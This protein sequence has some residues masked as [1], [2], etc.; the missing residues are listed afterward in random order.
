MSATTVSRVVR[1]A[2]VFT[3]VFALILVG[4]GLTVASLR[5]TG[6]LD[7]AIAALRPG[8][9]GAGL[10]LMLVGLGMTGPR[11]LVLL[12]PGAPGERPSALGASTLFL[13]VTV[14]NLSFPGPAGELAAAVA[15]KRRHGIPATTSIAASLHGRFAGLAG[16]GLCAMVLLPFV[17]V[18]EDHVWPLW[19]VAGGFG[20]AGL[21]LSGLALRP[22]LLARL[23][24][25]GP[26]W[27]AARLP[28][29][30]GRLCLRVQ[31]VVTDLADALVASARVGLSRWA[32]ALAWSLAAHTLYGLAVVCCGYGVAVSVPLLPALMA[33]GSSV[34][35]S[36]MMVLI[37]G[38]LGAWDASFSS[39]L[40]LAGG[41]EVADAA[42]VVVAVRLIQV[43]GMGVSAVAFMGWARDAMDARDRDGREPNPASGPGQGG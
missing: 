6:G 27:L 23:A 33:H 30:L 41:L 3:V 13:G 5:E 32:A 17:S 14:L 40:V 18:P 12:P 43:L 34:V 24:G 11:F 35:V 42:L 29:A 1:R 9:I 38:G 2:L 36:L 10:L 25:W 7:Q 8:W 4:I 26:G 21:V 31:R 19:M 28:G 37:P 22:T 39:V 16:A 15:L 20:L